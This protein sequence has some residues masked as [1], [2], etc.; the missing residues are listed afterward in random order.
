MLIYFI[1]I[2]LVSYMVMGNDKRKAKQGKWRIRESTLWLLALIGGAVGN[3]VAMQ[4]YRHKTKH[5]S[6]KYGMPVLALIDLGLLVY[7]S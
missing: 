6:F 5:L 4:T 2:N 3:W 1:L 7:F